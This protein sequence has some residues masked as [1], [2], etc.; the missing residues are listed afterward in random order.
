MPRLPKV[1]PCAFLLGV[2]LGKVQDPTAIAIAEMCSPDIHIRH[3]E[4]VRLGTPY[5]TVIERITALVAK[6]PDASLVVD[7]TGVGR[8]V[9]DQMRET[10][11]EPIPVTITG[12]RD[13]TFDGDMWRVPKK[14]LLRPLVAASEA[15]RLKVAKG[16][17]EAEAFQRELLAF[18]RRIT[19]SGHSAFE[20]VGAH[21]DLVIAAALI[22]WRVE[23]ARRLGACNAA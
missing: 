17:R 16:L 21:D 14:A 18:Q 15:G 23:I 3:L 19:E 4:R 6:L 13:M 11:L 1:T 7:A 22:C 10:G 2:D 20:G 5:P 8:P 12:G 9:I